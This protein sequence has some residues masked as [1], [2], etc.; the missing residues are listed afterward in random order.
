MIIFSLV[1]VGVGVLMFFFLQ[2]P[3]EKSP[4]IQLA[5]FMASTSVSQDVKSAKVQPITNT[6]PVSDLTDSAMNR[7]TR[8]DVRV[9]DIVGDLVIA[10]I[11]DLSTG[12]GHPENDFRIN[13][14]G[15]TTIT[16]T[17][18]IG[19]FGG[20][21]EIS[22]AITKIENPNFAP[23]LLSTSTNSQGAYYIVLNNPTTTRQAL[24]ETPR[25]VSIRIK[26][27]SVPWTWG[28]H[29]NTVADFVA[30]VQ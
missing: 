19:G 4:E 13:F 20:P 22:M 6:T 14:S 12:S 3:S 27:L 2:S 29:A 11:V 21:D 25:K 16:G 1:I 7:L 9:G 5:P 8:N 23:F 26:D 28:S 17:F 15:E 18:G 24:G 10:K 30:I